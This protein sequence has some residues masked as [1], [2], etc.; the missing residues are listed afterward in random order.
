MA[1]K[2]KKG[3]NMNAEERLEDLE[4]RV[5]DIEKGAEIDTEK[6]G[7]AIV[8]KLSRMGAKGHDKAPIPI[9]I[10]NDDWKNLSM[11]IREI[12][13]RVIGVDAMLDKMTELQKALERAN[14][15]ANEIADSKVEVIKTKL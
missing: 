10:E 3:K 7:D 13:Y 6:L 2:N 12:R 1:R 8:K 15:L 14:T 11:V 9:K 5:A 4:K